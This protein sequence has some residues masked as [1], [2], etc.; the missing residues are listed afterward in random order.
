GVL[1]LVFDGGLLMGDYRQAQHVVDGAATAAA[2]DLRLGKSNAEA[3][4]AAEQFIAAAEGFDDASVTVAIPPAAGPYAGRAGFVE[5]SL[6]KPY[7]SFL[8]QVVGAADVD[9]EVRAVAGLKSESPP[10]AIMVLDP[11]PSQLT[12]QS[13]PPL[14]PGP[15]TLLGGLEVE[16]LGEVSVDGTVIVNTTWG[17]VDENGDAAGESEPPPY[18]LTCMP[19]LP[20]TQLRAREIRVAGGVDVPENYGHFNAGEATPLDANA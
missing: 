19:L 4:A 9:F 15:L 18:A 10:T 11:D 8:I 20:L 13:I 6:R 12:I 2:M 14:L 5:V 3:V 16:G 7:Q 17:G 1:G